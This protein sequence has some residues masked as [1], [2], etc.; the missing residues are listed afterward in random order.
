MGIDAPEQVA[1]M[2]RVKLSPKLTILD[3]GCGTGLSGKALLAAGFITIDGIDV[4]RRSLEVASM[5]DA[6][7]T[8][9][10]IDLQRL[11]LPIPHWLYYRIKWFFLHHGLQCQ[12]I[13]GKNRLGINLLNNL[14]AKPD[15]EGGATNH[16]GGVALT[17]FL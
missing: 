7:R 4:S 5:T 1:S 2:L 10:A 3:A 13:Y 14:T 11:P 15:K 8:L 16:F 17:V 6:Y 12:G 9:R